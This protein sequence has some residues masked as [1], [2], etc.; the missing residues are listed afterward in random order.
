MDMMMTKR[1]IFALFSLCTSLTTF[2]SQTASADPTAPT[3]FVR[4]RPENPL[5]ARQEVCVFQHANFQGWKFCT[6]LKN[7]QTLPMPYQRQISSAKIPAGYQLRTFAR[8]DM[9]GGACIYFGEV[10]VMEGGCNDLATAISYENEPGYAQKQAEAAQRARDLQAAED[11]RQAQQREREADAQSYPQAVLQRQPPPEPSRGDKIAAL[12]GCAV[13][14][15]T[16]DGPFPDRICLPAEGEKRQFGGSW[17]DDIEVIVIKSPNIRVIGYE[18][19]NFTGN[20]VTLN[21]G[22]TELIGDPENEISSMKIF[23]S[24]TPFT[25]QCVGNR[26]GPLG[27]IRNPVRRWDF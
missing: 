18:H 11:A 13:E 16:T 22:D 9:A 5:V 17:N 27:T 6:T 10:A 2:A 26:N 12:G 15:L 4:R 19:A 8:P 24:E 25:N 20:K 23:Y 1:W 14:L 3:V 21:C 7:L